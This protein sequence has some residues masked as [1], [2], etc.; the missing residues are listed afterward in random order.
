MDLRRNWQSNDCCSEPVGM[1]SLL[2]HLTQ[3]PLVNVNPRNFHNIYMYLLFSD[4]AKCKRRTESATDNRLCYR[5]CSCCS[6][7]WTIF[8]FKQKPKMKLVYF[9]RLYAFVPFTPI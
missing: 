8:I 7:T 9:S 3:K 6:N 1:R 2:C 4:S 5:R